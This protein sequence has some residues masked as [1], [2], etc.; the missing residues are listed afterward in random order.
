MENFRHTVEVR[1]S[2]CDA[3][4]HVRHNAFADFCTHARIEWLRAHGFGYDRFQA[5]RFGPVIFKEWTEYFK[6]VR[7]SERVSIEVRIAALSED[8]SRF[9]I[10]H[11]LFRE[12]GK[13]AARHEIH[14]AW[15]D[16]QTRKL[17]M[18]PAQLVDIFDKLSRTED[19][20]IIPLKTV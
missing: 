16:L 6:E 4:Q 13:P 14:G 2:D 11:D 20:E 1:W 17:T 9:S 19:F 18:P 10:R 3:N 7:M 15:L 12:D 5:D 8:G